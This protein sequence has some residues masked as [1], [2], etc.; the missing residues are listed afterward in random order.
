MFHLVNADQCPPVRL[1]V[2]SFASQAL[3]KLRAA[4][5]DPRLNGTERPTLCV[6]VDRRSPAVVGRR[7]AAP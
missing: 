7:A 3:A 5:D 2:R 4:F 1:F 6:S